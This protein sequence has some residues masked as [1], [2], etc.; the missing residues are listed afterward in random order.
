MTP[1]TF[2]AAV[3]GRL[4]VSCQ[5]GEGHPL[6]DTAA[7]TRMA[8]AAEGGGAAAIRCGGVGGVPDV[9]AVAAAVDVPVIG[10]TK[11]GT[12]GVFITPTVAAARAVAAAGAHVVAA[13][14]TFRPRPDGRPVAATAEAVHDAGALFMADVS[15]LDEG[16]AAAKAGADA[17]ATTL[18]G[19]TLP[20]PPPDGPDLDLVR[21]LRDALPDALIVAEGRYHTPELAAAALEA[22]AT[23]VVVG[24]AITDPQWIASRFAAA[25][26]PP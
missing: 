23:C 1:E 11:D 24:T 4:I 14:A 18:A 15:S 22:G 2:A 17:V 26:G 13:D 6:R 5:A 19:H 12:G 9:A 16:V 3:A 10:L 21:A 20:G 8:R 7:L 25:L